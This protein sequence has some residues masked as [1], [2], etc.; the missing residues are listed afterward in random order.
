MNLSVN[1]S[2]STTSEALEKVLNL[3]DLQFY[4]LSNGKMIPISKKYLERLNDIIYAKSLAHLGM[5]YMKVIS[6]NKTPQKLL[7]DIRIGKHLHIVDFNPKTNIVIS[8][9]IIF[10]CDSD[11]PLAMSPT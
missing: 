8:L 6:N 10:N 11:S 5:Q 7:N 9:K 2:L 1:P 4:F 3:L